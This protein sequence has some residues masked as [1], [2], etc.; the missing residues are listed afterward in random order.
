MRWTLQHILLVALATVSVVDPVA[1][2][3]T[4]SIRQDGS[5]DV[6]SLEDALD[7]LPN[8]LDDPYILEFQDSET[9]EETVT[10]DVNIRNGG[11]LT[12]TAAAGELP[13]LQSSESE[14]PVLILESSGV[15]V[16][17]LILEGGNKQPG[18]HI[19]W[20]DNHTIRGCIIRGTRQGKTAGIYIQG[21]QNN[22][23]VDNDI[24]DNQVGVRLFNQADNNVIRNNRIY[25]NLVRGLWLYK[26]SAANEILHNSFEQN[27]IEIHIGNEGKAKDEPGQNNQFLHNVVVGGSGGTVFRVR[28]KGDPGTLPPNTTSDYNLLFAPVGATFGILDNTTATDL[29]SWQAATGADAHSVS[30]DP[31]FV[32]APTDLHLQSTV[33]S[34]HDGA[35]TAD[36]AH[37]PGID[38]GDV[39]AAVGDEPDPHGSRLNIGAYGGTAQASLAGA[40][41][42]SGAFN[43]VTA[44]AEGLGQHEVSIEISHPGGLLSNARIEW[45]TAAAGPFAAATLA[46]PVTADEGT[47]VINNAASYQ[48]S[49]IETGAGSNTV[50]LRWD[51]ATDLGALDGAAWLRLT[52]ND[53]STDQAVAA[54]I[55]VTVDNAPPQGLADLATAA[56]FS[57]R[58]QLTWTAATTESHFD[59][60]TLWYATSS[61]DV[62]NRSGSAAAW[63]V[64][65]DPELATLATGSTTITSLQPNTS[66]FV[67]IWG[68]DTYGNQSSD[69]QT[70]A[71]TTNLDTIIHYVA[72]SGSNTG[73]ANDLGQPWNS[74]K[75]AVD[76]IPADLV[77]AEATYVVH[78]LDSSTYAETVK[79]DKDH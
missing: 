63:T 25:R 64:V 16:E 41:A 17:G 66:Y 48:N 67:Q 36:A 78:I 43:S 10:V 68:R 27:A 13:I 72:A 62:Q 52:A 23:V 9:Y 34:Y 50:V 26:K 32:A 58:I 24:T 45:A 37:S 31:L 70:T 51:S 77:A 73:E 21:G 38:A 1:A 59:A 20:S 22:L 79:I 2:Q 4:I 35:W 19:D 46:G 14:K 8:H 49:S 42:P 39:T 6:T 15:T 30:A 61:A 44:L 69:G 33:G 40:A 55:G 71:Q 18:V 3:T 60:Y 54:V 57:S 76:A 7:A 56:G 47:P 29:G 28:R 74:I 65:H 5:G 75:R 11:S 12:I 53:G